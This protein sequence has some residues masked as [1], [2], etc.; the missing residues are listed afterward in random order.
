MIAGTLS[1][2]KIVEEQARYTAGIAHWNVITP[3]GL[4]GFILFMIAATAETNRSPFDLPEGESEIIAG[5]FIEYSGF[6]FALFFLAEYIEMFAV[7]GLAIT[8]F[9]GGWSSPVS[10]LAWIPSWLWFFGKLLAMIFGFIWV[11]GTMPRLRMDQLMNFAWK[12][13]L[14]MTL[15]V[16]LSAG[17]WRF[18]SPGVVGPRP[19]GGVIR[20]LVCALV[21]F[22]PYILLAR[23]L[24]RGH[25]MEKRTYRF[26]E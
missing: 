15:I 5:Y 22:A 10:F 16:I 21:I 18:L 23:K 17:I 14:P 12:F 11:R 20:W 9:L 1:T 3:W 26:A 24:E 13:M 8:L 2:V 25:S 6:K 7:S 19:L 4:A